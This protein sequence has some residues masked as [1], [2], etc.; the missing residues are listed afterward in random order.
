MTGVV[1]TVLGPVPAEELGVIAIHESLLSVLPGAEYAYDISMDKAE[2]FSILARSLREFSDAGGRTVVDATGMFH[3]RDLALYEALSTSTGVHIVASTGMGPEEMLGGYYLTPQTN[4]PT[5]WPAEKF[6]DLFVKEIAEGMVVPRLERRA[7]AGLIVTAAAREGMT[8]TEES[9]FRAAARTSRDTGVAVSIRFGSDAL[10]DLGI[11]IDEGLPADR[12]A[13]SG[14]DRADAVAAGIPIAVARLGAYAAID[15]VGTAGVQGL[16]DDKDRVRLV[17]ELLEAG[18]GDRI[19]L[20]SNSVGVAKGHATSE[21]SL[22]AVLTSFVPALRSAGV[23][24]ASIHLLL[25]ANP[26]RFL[27]QQGN[28]RA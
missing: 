25:Q 9:L 21:V 18:L 20:S 22:S 26:Q 24:E 17:L 6:A 10:H 8:A 27:A 1:S 3:G 5:P 13:V 11:V 4:P 12:I 23:D 19:L 7:P 16:L 2:I 14:M 15:S 28:E